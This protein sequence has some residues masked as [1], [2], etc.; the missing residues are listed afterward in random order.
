MEIKEILEMIIQYGSAPVIM[1]IFLINYTKMM[2]ENGKKQ[3]EDNKQVLL[4]MEKS[5]EKLNGLYMNDSKMENLVTGLITSV[6]KLT[7]AT[8]TV[9]TVVD[10]MDI[11]NK[12]STKK[13]DSHD[14]RSETILRNSELVLQNTERILNKIGG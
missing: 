11:Y 2:N 12:E 7:S 3:R 4:Q 10:R 6:E 8:E 13:L 9:V 1:G 5:I 14:T